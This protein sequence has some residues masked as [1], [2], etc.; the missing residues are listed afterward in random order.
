MSVALGIKPFER[1]RRSR[2]SGVSAPVQTLLAAG[3][4][5][6]AMRVDLQ[7]ATRAGARPI[8]VIVEPHDTVA[9]VLDQM[10]D[11]RRDRKSARGAA[12]SHSTVARACGFGLPAGPQLVES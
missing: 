7:H 11:R 4:A 5:Q 1:Q 6:D 2:F 9:S 10:R 3:P 8:V 12:A